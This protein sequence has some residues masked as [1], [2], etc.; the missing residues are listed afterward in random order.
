LE[1]RHAD[2]PEVRVNM[3]KRE[4]ILVLDRSGA[5]RRAPDAILAGWVDRAS[6]RALYRVED[7]MKNIIGIILGIVLIVTGTAVLAYQ[8]ITVTTAARQL[9][10]VGPIQA[11]T[12]QANWTITLPPILGALLLAGGT[13]VVF[14]SA[15]LRKAVRPRVHEPER[16]N[17]LTRRLPQDSGLAS[18]STS[19]SPKVPVT[20][21]ASPFHS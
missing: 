5:L 1:K 17:Q 21:P 18:E 9:L 7:F 2:V 4:S 11:A 20:R 14:A 13:G 8:G 15:L 16:D 3:T 6:N 19:R 12:Q 10:H